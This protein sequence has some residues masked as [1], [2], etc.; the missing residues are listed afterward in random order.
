VESSK[1][2]ELLQLAREF[3]LTQLRIGDFEAY[4][5][6]KNDTTVKSARTKPPTEELIFPKGSMLNDP[7]LYASVVK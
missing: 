6:P 5:A 1:V 7:D 2:K 4:F 3:G